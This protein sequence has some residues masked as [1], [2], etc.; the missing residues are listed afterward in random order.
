MAR[1]G[2]VF[3]LL[4]FGLTI[5]G[6]STTSQ[7]TYTQ[8]IPMMF[9]IPLLFL[10]VVALNPHRRGESVFVALL[11]ALLCTILGG[12]RL[13]S[14]GF[15]WMAGEHINPLSVRL[16]AG[17][18]II[19][20]VFVIVAE[21][22]RR[23]RRRSENAAKSSALSSATTTIESATSAAENVDP[24][25]AVT[26]ARGDNENPYKTPAILDAPASISPPTPAP[27]SKLTDH[28]P[29]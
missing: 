18:T 17:M 8:F 14:L 2:I 24:S 12:G 27:S 10:G 22:W 29:K 23:N 7:K 9:G 4:L 28:T 13:I 26:R 5:A 6:L 3:G 19:G 25:A 16:V 11:L 20:G 21:R 15:A 1:I